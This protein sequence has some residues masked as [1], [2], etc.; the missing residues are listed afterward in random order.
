MLDPY[1]MV[2][3]NVFCFLL[4]ILSLLFYRYIYPK[5][6]IHLVVVLLLLSLLPLI[7]SLRKGSYESGD[8]VNH[9]KIAME[10]MQPLSEGIFFPRSSTITCEGYGCPD[11]IFMY[12][13]PPYSINF[14]HFLGLSFI[15]SV[16]L[17]LAV[18]FIGSGITMYLWIKETIGKVPAFVGALFYLYAPYHLVDMHF[19]SDVGEMAS[20]AILPLAFLFTQKIIENKKF[21][22]YILFGITLSVLILSHQ[23]ISLTSL[24]FILLYGIFLW[25]QTKQKNLKTLLYYSFATVYGLALSCFYWVPILYEAKYMFWGVHGDISFV[26]LQQL[27]YSPWRYGLLF[28]GHNGELSFVVGYI[29]LLMIMLA[30]YFL[31]RKKIITKN[32]NYLLFFL[33]SFF[34]LFFLMQSSSFLFWKYIPIIKSIQYSYRLLLLTSVFTSFIAAIVVTRIKNKQIVIG[35][36]CLVVATTLLNWGNRKSL[37]EINDVS[38]KKQL[39]TIDPGK[40]SLTRPIWVGEGDIY[41]DSPR[42]KTRL[43]VI[44]G[45]AVIRQIYLT[46]ARHEYLVSTKT[47]TFFKENSFYFP[48]WIV[49][50]N[51]Q[52]YPITYTFPK[53]PGLITFTLPQGIYKVEVAFIDTVD[54]KIS[55]IISAFTLFLSMSSLLF[56]SLKK[57]PIKKRWSEK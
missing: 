8:L 47:K 48:G 44:T 3:V 22:W 25:F 42:P 10:F 57:I 49:M 54:R 5:R 30:F 12:L 56:I 19:R 27:L 7:S 53:Y 24:P 2:F 55:K 39:L 46:S 6:K 41:W 11:F 45:N 36:C 28:Q 20:Y 9:V 34:T 50:V 15:A 17:F 31:V 35:I 38:I 43:E 52:Q 29:H 14:F 4:L 40:G 51:D 16:K 32:K 21:H 26:P 33:I 18:T 23:A 37:P 13:L 1:K